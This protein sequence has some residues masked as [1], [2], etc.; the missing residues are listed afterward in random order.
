MLNKIPERVIWACSPRNPAWIFKY[1]RGVKE[2]HWIYRDNK[3]R[4]I[5]RDFIDFYVTVNVVY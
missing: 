4:G 3:D 5:L 2:V 1:F